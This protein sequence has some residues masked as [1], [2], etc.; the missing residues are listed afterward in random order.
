MLAIPLVLAL[1]GIRDWRCY[2]VAACWAPVFNGA[3]NVNVSIPIAV[4]VALAW[5]Y[6]RSPLGS[7]LGVGCAVATKIFV[8]PLLLWP[9][10][11]RRL[12]ALATGVVAAVVLVFGS[13]AAIGFA[14]LGSYPTLLRTLT[15]YEERSSYSVSGALAVVG[16]P[17]A[18][19]RGV[20]LVLTAALCLLCLVLGRRGDERRAFAAAVLAALASTPILWQHYLVILLVPLAVC[21]PRLSAAWLLPVLLWLAP[22]T[23]NGTAAQTLL[24]PV[25]AALVGAACLAPERQP[26]AEPLRF[27]RVL[28]PSA[29]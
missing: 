17:V 26:D 18:G 29:L 28:R 25:V 19:A 9:L 14:G 2:A 5:R 23:G 7:G 22:F 12:R 10:A 4:L 1:V 6:R 13:W 24:V 27:S 16:L 11:A 21:R 15:S 20:A 8:W 3:Q